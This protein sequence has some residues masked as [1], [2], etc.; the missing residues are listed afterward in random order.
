MNTDSADKLGIEV[1][2]DSADKL[3][4]EVAEDLRP[5]SKHNWCTEILA[6]NVDKHFSQIS[7]W[8]YKHGEAG[9][10]F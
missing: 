9:V 2:T 8:P 3:G 6:W 5:A 10:I 1:N 4:I 7:F